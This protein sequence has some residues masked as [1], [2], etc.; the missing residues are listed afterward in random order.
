MLPQVNE[1][2]LLLYDCLSAVVS[3]RSET[4]EEV[5]HSYDRLAYWP[6]LYQ[7]QHELWNVRSWHFR[8]SCICTNPLNLPYHYYVTDEVNSAEALH[9]RAVSDSRNLNCAEKGKWMKKVTFSLQLCFLR[10]SSSEKVDSLRKNV[11]FTSVSSDF[12]YFQVSQVCF[13]P[14]GR[15]HSLNWTHLVIGWDTT[16]CI[17]PILFILGEIFSQNIYFEA[18]IKWKFGQQQSWIILRGYFE[19]ILFYHNSMWFTNFDPFRKK[20]TTPSVP[21]SKWSITRLI[22]LM[23]KFGGSQGCSKYWS[24]G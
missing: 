21:A 6:N 5:I 11:M 24:P 4:L 9:V 14:Q 20:K 2:S 19:V 3:Y 15:M 12:Y 16:D 10:L 22:T 13:M 23:T 17:W 1:L 18:F 7:A 8:D